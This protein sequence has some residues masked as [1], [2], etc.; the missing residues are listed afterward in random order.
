MTVTMRILGIASM[1]RCIN[2]NPSHSDMIRV[3][4]P[5]V[6]YLGDL[7]N[8]ECYYETLCDLANHLINLLFAFYVLTRRPIFVLS[9]ILVL[10]VS[11]PLLAP[12]SLLCSRPLSSPESSVCVYPSPRP[13]P[14][15]IASWIDVGVISLKSTRSSSLRADKFPGSLRAQTG[16]RRPLNFCGLAFGLVALS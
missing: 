7:E 9:Q 11:T 8:V 16:T 10:S 13:P 1:S 2:H 3:R 6:R 4:S 15:F 14:A 12:Q 5:P